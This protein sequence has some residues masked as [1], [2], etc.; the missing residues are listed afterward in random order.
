MKLFEQVT[1]QSP[2]FTLTRTATTVEVFFNYDLSGWY[3][4]E[5]GFYVYSGEAIINV[6]DVDRMV[7]QSPGGDRPLF[8]NFTA[9]LTSG[10][11]YQNE[12]T[13]V[14]WG[15]GTDVTFSFNMTLFSLKAVFNGTQAVDVVFGSLAGDVLSGGGGDD[16]IE[17]HAGNDV[18]NGGE[19]KDTLYGG[20]GN[21][22]YILDDLGDRVVEAASE[23]YD[24]VEASFSYSLGANFEALTLVGSSAIGGTGN[25]GANVLTGNIA[26]NIL[27][28]GAGADTMIGGMGNDAYIVSDPGDKISEKTGEGFDYVKASVTYELAANIEDLLLYASAGAINGFGNTLANSIKGN[29]SANVL[30]GD[31]GNDDLS[32]NGGDDI[33]LGGDGDDVLRGGTGTDR[34]YGGNGSDKYAVDNA[35]DR[36]VEATGGGIDRVLTSTSFVLTAGAEVESFAT[37][38]ATGFDA[39][40]LTGN[41]FAQTITGNL[42]ANILSGKGGN[43]TLKGGGGADKLL[44]G[45]GADKLYG[46][47]GT[48]IFVFQ[49]Y[50]SSVLSGRDIIYDFS[51]EA[52]EKIDLSALDA[53][54]NISGNQAFTFIGEKA[55]S[56]KA[57]E[58]RYVNASGDTYLYG[59][60]NGDRIT[61][62]SVRLNT[63]I[64]FVKGDFIL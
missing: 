45:S 11:T 5:A 59:D 20:V 37:T 39:I 53:N 8:M 27:D 33:L 49:S 46:G 50:E 6:G 30:D 58:L 43:D 47:A 23:G 36:I 40:N 9:S 22:T 62:F 1:G 18:L 63:T 44:G 19:G 24:L 35:L 57:G 12:Y 28:G 7:Y 2:E 17:G 21:D 25:S 13:V 51:Q 14:D 48:D 15:D 3:D 34:L 4:E 60:A 64:E 54:R 41:E 31:A 52:G 61:D 26:N 32:G 10:V 56:S 42:G 29:E 55:F 38:Q 16:F